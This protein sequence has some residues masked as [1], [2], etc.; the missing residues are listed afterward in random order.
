MAKAKKL[1]VVYLHD[2]RHLCNRNSDHTVLFRTSY[3]PQLSLSELQQ[4]KLRNLVRM[5]LAWALHL[6]RCTH[7]LAC[8]CALCLVCRPEIVIDTETWHD[9]SPVSK[10]ARVY[11]CLCGVN[12]AFGMLK[13]FKYL[14]TRKRVMILWD[15]LFEGMPD[16]MTVMMIFL[17]FVSAV[18]VS[19]KRVFG[20]TD[21]FLSYLDVCVL[22]VPKPIECHR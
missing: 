19:G 20:A 10:D 6:R 18:A 16:I 11:Q 3:V 7:E 15:T 2:D 17:L 1:P 13:V 14:R 21:F 5:H 9:F 4:R 22:C 8:S 12:L